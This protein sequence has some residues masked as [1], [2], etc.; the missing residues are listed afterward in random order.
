MH[1]LQQ[2]LAKRSYSWESVA[3]ATRGEAVRR[4]RT[5]WQRLRTMLG[6]LGAR[7][8]RKW[9]RSSPEA[10]PADVHPGFRLSGAHS[11]FQDILGCAALLTR[12]LS[13]PRPRSVA[14]TSSVPHR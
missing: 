10:G 5:L 1:D 4:Q 3:A 13:E 2:Y 12:A 7:R 14:D 9:V 11:G 8:L 6:D